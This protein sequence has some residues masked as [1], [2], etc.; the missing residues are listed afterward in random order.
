MFNELKLNVLM[1]CAVII[2]V[3]KRRDVLEGISKLDYLLKVSIFQVFKN[4]ML[5]S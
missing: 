1:L 5:R 3:K 2:F 4:P